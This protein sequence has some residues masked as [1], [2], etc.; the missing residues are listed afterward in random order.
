MSSTMMLLKQMLTKKIIRITTVSCLKCGIVAVKNHQKAHHDYKLCF[1]F[2]PSINRW[3]LITPEWGRILEC[4]LFERR[5][6]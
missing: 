6:I 1:F 4:H 3:V 2:Q 5:Y